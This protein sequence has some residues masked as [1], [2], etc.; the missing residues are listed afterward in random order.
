M[1]AAATAA[2]ERGRVA[3]A[4]N[5]DV[6]TLASVELRPLP[7]AETAAAAAASA[8][9]DGSVDGAATNTFYTNSNTTATAYGGTMMSDEEELPVM[10]APDPVAAACP[11][12]L[13]YYGHL[14]CRPSCPVLLL[15][16]EHRVNNTLVDVMRLYG[17]TLPLPFVVAVC[18]GVLHGLLFLHGR[19]RIHGDLRPEN[20]HLRA[21][22]IA[23]TTTTGLDPPSAAARA[24]AVML[25]GYVV[26][27]THGLPAPTTVWCPPLLSSAKGRKVIHNTAAADMYSFGLI[28]LVM[29]R[30]ALRWEY[31]AVDDADSSKA[32]ERKAFV[33]RVVAAGAVR[34]VA[35]VKRGRIC[36][37][38]RQPQL[39]PRRQD[40]D[41]DD[42]DGEGEGE[43]GHH[44][45]LHPAAHP[46]HKQ[47][48]EREAD[49]DEDGD[50]ANPA[51]PLATA[52]ATAR[53]TNAELAAAEAAVQA[54]DWEQ[55][56]H[57]DRERLTVGALA[58]LAQRCM[59][60][61]RG[62]RIK[63]RAALEAVARLE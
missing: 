54:E 30:C 33:A 48:D 18:S 16:T 28:V 11:F 41:D 24:P 1:A 23:P 60:T 32:C 52:T 38:S 25:G 45:Q 12:L 4:L 20:I 50:P 53:S 27:E 37:A 36:L 14:D 57:A 17:R 10:S 13:R 15:L 43:D 6:G 39:A 40:D 35:E 22:P 31:R 55:V 58:A 51:A 49:D 61:V 63:V 3:I 47:R 2:A 42:D 8:G 59:S 7:P 46:P 62:T 34:F 29:L 44:Q 56:T 21:R 26:V 19:H 9:G 5:P